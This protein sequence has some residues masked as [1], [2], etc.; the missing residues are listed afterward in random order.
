MGG[1]TRAPA[2]AAVPAEGPAEVPAGGL[3]ASIATVCLAGA[4]PEKLQAAAAAGFDAVELFEPD[5]LGWHEPP[6]VVRARV[7]DLGLAVSLSQPFRDP[8]D[9]DPAAVARTVH[10]LHRK[11][12]VARALGTD[13]LLVCSA[14]HA[15]AVRDDEQLADQLRTLAQVAAG[16][17]VR[18]AYEAL[19]WGA[20]VDDHRHAH[21]IVEAVDHP[22]LGTCLD[23]FHVLS[24]GGDP[25]DVAAMAAGKLFFYQ[26]ADAPRLSMGVLPWS[27]H[28]RCFPGQGGFDLVGF[29]AAVLATGYRGPVSLEVFNDLFRQADPRVTAVDGMRSLRHL[30]DRVAR[31]SPEPD[32]TATTVP[33]APAT[34]LPT[35][36][37][38]SSWAFVEVSTSPAAA[39]SVLELLAH[40]GFSRS[41]IHRSG[42]VELWSNAD[43]RV[44][45]NQRHPDVLA[46]VSSLGLR[47][48]R[49]HALQ[50]RAREL[51]AP[52]VH[53]AVGPGEAEI[54]SLVA[55]DGTWVQFCG[56]QEAGNADWLDDF[57]PV[58]PPPRP[59]GDGPDVSG[60]ALSGID[61][62]ALP[63]RFG[64]FDTA[65]LFLS[66]VLGLEP[67]EVVEVPGPEGLVRSRALVSD[68]GAVRIVLNVSPTAAMLKGRPLGA[69]HVA[70]ATTDAIAAARAFARAG[71]RPLPVPGNYYDDL[72]ARYGLAAG[73]LEDLRECSVLYDRDGDGELLHFFTRSL[74]PDLFVE[75]VQRVGGYAGFG[76]GNSP[77]RLSAQR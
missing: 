38:P 33:S 56:A 54:P 74:S 55:P 9:V 53:R 64:G 14:V 32:A 48:S 28:H 69:G 70:F 41:G 8:D 45:V 76:A 15:G 40:L 10:R 16:H 67:R 75:V 26:V 44:V 30:A 27:R 49:P 35:A 1:T 60:P 61:H 66:C 63:Q 29:H 59:D 20:H 57:L 22:S 68:G 31:R 77:V 43:V 6:A 24:R 4:L 46:R 13:L 52:V 39:G 51:L 36:P 37:S 65:A 3:A 72:E 7:A 2:P 34:A 12:E 73:F 42:P 21:R 17:G 58:P 62:V 19:A 50:E 5:L 25:A 18:L 23:S 71:G 47:T 11:C